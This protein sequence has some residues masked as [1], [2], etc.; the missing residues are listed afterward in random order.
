MLERDFSDVLPRLDLPSR[1]AYIKP[2][3]NHI[4]LGQRRYL[5]KRHLISVNAERFNVCG[6]NSVLRKTGGWRE[7]LP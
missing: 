7:L 5:L 3:S 4:K 2:Y 6:G 1:Y